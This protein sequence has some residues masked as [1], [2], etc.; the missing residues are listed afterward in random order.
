[1]GWWNDRVVPRIVDKTLK[2]HGDRGDSR[3]RLRKASTAGSSR[4]GSAA[5]STSARTRPRSPQVDAVEPSAAGL[6]DVRER[7]RAGPPCRS[8]AS[9]GTPSGSRSPTR[10]TTARWSPSPSARSRT[11]WRRC[12]EVR[13]V[14]KPGA[15]VHFLEHGVADDP[16]VAAWQ[17][18]L[19]PLQRRLAGG[20]HLTRDPAVLDPRRPAWRSSTVRAGRPPDG[21]RVPGPAGV[22]GRRG[23][24]RPAPSVTA[25]CA[26][27]PPRLTDAMRARQLTATMPGHDTTSAGKWSVDGDGRD[28]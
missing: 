24:R 1:M 14:L 5:A 2:G 26:T 27:V 19:D 10:P 20:C 13:R 7:R 15:S 25:A 21:G 16:T 8:S 23:A 17:R 18:R 12:A 9:A 3:P 11:P 22:L 6:G 28:R 4:S